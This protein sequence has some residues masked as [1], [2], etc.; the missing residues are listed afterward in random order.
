MFTNV[1]FN[2][3]HVFT[4]FLIFIW[5]FFLHLWYGIDTNIIHTQSHKCKILCRSPHD[6]GQN[7]LS[8]PM[9]VSAFVASVSTSRRHTYKLHR[10]SGRR[11]KTYAGRIGRG[12]LIIIRYDTIRNVILTCAQTLTW[13]SLIYRTEP[14][15]K[16]ENRKKNKK[17][18]CSEVSVN[19]PWNPWSNSWRRKGRLRWVGFAEIRFAEKGRFKHEMKEW[20]VMEY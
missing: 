14:R 6:R 12:Q 9:D 17:R 4:F 8:C 5:T 10:S 15:T 1:F 19:S 20:G 13:I 3:C 7:H 18:I 2:F 16:K 11:A